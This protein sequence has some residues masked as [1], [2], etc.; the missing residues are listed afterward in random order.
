MSRQCRVKHSTCRVSA[1]SQA[2]QNKLCR[3]NAASHLSH[4]ASNLTL[5]VSTS[6]VTPM[7]RHCRVTPTTCRVNPH[8][9]RQYFNCQCNLNL[10]EQC[11]HDSLLASLT[12]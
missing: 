11:P 10:S 3:V 9:A 5:R 4:A 12:L 6:A 8:P 7:P 1:A 2:R